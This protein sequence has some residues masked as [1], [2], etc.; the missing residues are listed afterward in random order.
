MKRQNLLVQDRKI[1]ALEIAGTL[2]IIFLGTALHFT[3]DFSG[4]NPLVGAFSAVNESVWEH[5]KLPFW[6]SLLWMLIEMYPL[7]KEINNFFAAKTIGIIVM[8]VV[9]PV[10][11]YAYTAFT[12]EILAVDIAT[13]MIAVFMGQIISY[14]LFK[15]DKPS[16]RTEIIAIIV[17]ALIA[18]IFV[19]FTYYPLH[20][21]IFQDSNTHQYGILGL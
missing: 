3:F 13:F 1:L 12:E 11:F 20:L 16:R 7:K 21:S 5:L 2:F 9:I 8:I 6:P 14:R 10:V 19:A 18:I 4:R 15:K 17:I